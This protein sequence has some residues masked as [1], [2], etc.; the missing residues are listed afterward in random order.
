VNA[1]ASTNATQA[2]ASSGGATFANTLRSE[3][4]KLRTIRMN[5]VL[6]VLAVGLPLVICVLTAA[7]GG[8]E[9]GDFANG[10]ETRF[11]GT[12]ENLVGLVNGTAVITAM[13]L[14]VIGASSITGEFG[15]NTIRPT[16]AATPKRLRVLT[17]KGI[18]TALSALVA[19]ALV[20]LTCLG[21]M[22]AIIAARG[23]ELRPFES[24]VSC[25]EFDTCE[26]IT[27]SWWP[28]IIGI[29]LFAVIVALLGYGIGL[30]IRNTPAAIAVLILWPLVV[31][32]LIIGILSA[33]G[34]NRAER[35]LPYVSGF[36]LGAPTNEAGSIGRVGGGLYFAAVTFVVV[37]LGALSTNRRDA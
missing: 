24:Y 31:E 27:F 37:A 35:F 9:S 17:A 34:V 14:G 10:R 26:A 25:D 7:L 15:F 30:L 13:L 36:N 5:W 2:A 4:I 33:A 29:L 32:G 18:I 20:V 19:Q 1:P 6:F 28:P 22:R 12:T 8:A 16:F 21:A 23:L 3:W 11:F